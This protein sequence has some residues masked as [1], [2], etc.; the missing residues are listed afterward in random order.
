MLTTILL[1]AGSILGA[2]GIAFA[3]WSIIDTRKK[4][5]EE[6]LRRR[7]RGASD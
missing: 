6:Y 3:I 7:R 2:A 1:V 4:Y 5:Y